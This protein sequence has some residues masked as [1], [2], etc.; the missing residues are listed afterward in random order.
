M[1]KWILAAGVFLIILAAGI[2]YIAI[3]SNISFSYHLRI[4][5][6]ARGG[7]RV[8]TDSA[9]WTKWRPQDGDGLSYRMSGQYNY[10]VYFRV[11]NKGDSLNSRMVLVP[12]TNPD[13]SELYWD[14]GLPAGGRPIARIEH[15]LF[16]RKVSRDMENILFHLR[17]FLENK[18]NVYGVKIEP[19]TTQ[20][21]F[22]VA[23]RAIFSYDPSI[24]DIYGLLH[25]VERWVKKEGAHETGYPMLNITRLGDGRR[26]MEVAVPVDRKIKDEGVFYSRKMV[27]GHYLM[28][29]VKG[30]MAVIDR[31]FGQMQNYVNDYQKTTM[32]IPFQSLVTDRIQEPDTT[33]W[34]T[35]IYFPVY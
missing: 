30:G 12:S 6:N 24:G 22:L 3:P 7:L 28:T 33:R 18:E 26:Q 5:C 1:Q 17:D 19:A 13:S 32:A 16:G 4:A 15:Y 23:I 9:N 8:I 11:E 10:I 2:I 25:A 14:F 31:A 27:P 29:E 34:I 21:S 20:D 35:R